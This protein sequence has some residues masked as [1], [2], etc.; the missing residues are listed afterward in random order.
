MEI[1]LI[2]HSTQFPHKIWV[3][4]KYYSFLSNPFSAPSILDLTCSFASTTQ[5]SDVKKEKG[6]GEVHFHTT[7]SPK[8]TITA[9][10]T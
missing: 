7:E 9:K 3:S 8:V 2:R 10:N 5:M 4:W 6:M 1:C